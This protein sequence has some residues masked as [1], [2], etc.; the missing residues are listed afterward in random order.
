MP[1]RQ[2][3]D[4]RIVEMRID[5]KRFESGAKNTISTLEKLQKALHLKADSKA[6]DDM[7][8]SV[9]KFDANPMVKSLEK[10]Q[11]S[12]SALE[13]AGMR[14]ITNLTDSI[15]NFATRTAKA[16]TI[17]QVSAGFNKYQKMIESTQTI[18]AATASEV[19]E[20]GRWAN[21][22]EQMQD[23]QKYLDGLLWYADETSYSFVDMTDNLGKFLSAGVDL[24]TAYK[25]MMG[26]AS[27][28]ATAGAKVSD[29]SRALYNISQ[30]MGTGAMKAIDW[31]SIEN[32]NM[33]TIDFK[34]N[35]LATAV[36]LGKLKLVTNDLVDENGKLR[37]GYVAAGVEMNDAGHIINATDEEVEK[38]L[39]TAENMRET[40]KDE[41]FDR[42]VMESVFEKY[43]RFAEMLHQ[44]TSDNY[45]EAIYNQEGQAIEGL[46]GSLLE[47]TD[48]LQLLDEYRDELADPN[49]KVDW[50]AWIDAA[51]LNGT[52]EEQ[53]EQLQALVKLLDDVG[54]AYSETG[55]RMGQEA[56]TFE[57]ALEATKDAVSSQWMKSF[58]Y[59][60]GDYMQAKEFWTQVTGELWDIFAAGGVR[61]NQI[62]KEW[63]RSVDDVTGRTGRDYLLGTWEE[64]IDGETV[65][66]KGALWNLLDAV[67]TI[68]GPIHEAFEEVFGIDDDQFGTT[69]ERL[70]ELTR[71]FQEFTKTL[72]FSE[73]A[74]AGLKTI[75]TGVFKTLKSGIKFAAGVID[76]FGRIAYAIGQIVDAGIRL[77]NGDIDFNGFLGAIRDAIGSILPS[78]EKIIELYTEIKKK[79]DALKLSLSSGTFWETAKQ[80]IPTLTD[81]Q[82]LI[83][84]IT[85]YLGEKFPRIFGKFREWEGSSFLGGILSS[86]ANGF[87]AFANSLKSL[88]FETTT[89][90]EAIARFNEVVTKLFTGLFGDPEELSAQIDNF[91]TTVWNTLKARVSQLSFGDILKLVKTTSI[92]IVLARISQVIN[93]FRKLTDEASGIKEAF[94]GFLGQAGKTLEAIGK[95]YKADAFIKL[96]IAIGILT[97]SLIALSFVPEDKLVNVAVTLAML[98]GVISLFA[99]RLTGATN[100][101]TGIDKSK[102]LSGNRLTIFSSL[103]S[104]LIGFGMVIAAVAGLILVA[105]DL[106][107]NTLFNIFAGIAA[108]ILELTIVIKYLSGMEFSNSKGVIFTLVAIGTVLNM[109]I[110]VLATLAIISRD[111]NTYLSAV[112]GTIGL[113]AALG[114][115]VV[116]IGKFTKDNDN[117]LKVAGSM[118]LM[119]LA[120]QMLIPILVLFTLMDSKAFGK[121]IAGLLSVMI[122]LGGFFALISLLKVDGKKM[123]AL[124][125]AMA[126]I[127]LAIDLMIPALAGF[128]GIVSMLSVA[129]NWKKIIKDLG[130]FWKALGKLAL[131]TVVLAVIGASFIAIGVGVM[132]FGAGLILAGVGAVALAAGLVPL[133]AVLPSFIETLSNINGWKLTAVIA[134]FAVFGLAVLGVVKILKLLTGNNVGKKLTEF[135]SKVFGGLANL[136]TKVGNKIIEALPK[137]LDILGTVLIIIGLYITGIIP[138]LTEIAVTAIITLFNSIA[139]SVEKNRDA[140]VDSIMRII[141]TALGIAGDILGNLFDKNWISENLSHTEQGLLSIL[142]TLLLIKIAAASIMKT[143]KFAATIKGLFTGGGAAAG[144]GGAGGA[145]AGGAGWL[146]S[147]AKSLTAAGAGLG[148]FGGAAT[149]ATAGVG[150][151][152]AALGMVPFVLLD[153]KLATEYASQA[154]TET[155]NSIGGMAAKMNELAETASHYEE[156][157]YDTT[158]YTAQLGYSAQDCRYAQSALESMQT[159]LA[160]SLGIT[161]DELLKQVEAADGDYTKVVELQQ[162]TRDYANE[163]DRTAYIGRTR[164]QM[165]AE[166]F[167]QTAAAAEDSSTRI[168]VSWQE[169]ASQLQANF[170]ELPGFFSIINDSVTESAETAGNSGAVAFANGFIASMDDSQM[171]TAM[172][173]SGFAALLETFLGAQNSTDENASTV[174]ENAAIGI[175][176]SLGSMQGQLFDAGESAGNA[177]YQG[178]RYGLRERSP[179]KRMA[180]VGLYAMLG[181]IKGIEENSDDVNSAGEEVSN[182]FFNAVRQAMTRVSLLAN[183]EFSISPLITPVV[184][185]SNVTAAAS[186]ISGS[187]AGSRVGVAA[188]YSNSISRRLNQVERVASNMENNA[189]MVSGDSIVFNIY[190]SEGM[191]EEAIADTVLSKMQSRYARRGVAFG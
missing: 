183:D 154:Y 68:T 15:Y 165:N 176:N 108:I 9:E 136:I 64:E 169:T 153:N 1:N 161:R 157:L 126:L 49:K 80:Y 87:Q 66:V 160:A 13:I 26:I 151:L 134:G 51:G 142:K 105:R 180:E 12:F 127:A 28:G 7:G 55:F 178:A 44:V 97:A 86:L 115:L 62:L 32:A 166:S 89:I 40:L 11:M 78:E 168:G 30:A 113:M 191:D 29:V 144:A 2:N 82:N 101:I 135:G 162:A 83:A 54:L 50:N 69:A 152:L 159:Q 14:V 85:T 181:M 67:R 145:A 56:K 8:R 111:F 72:G 19:G 106:D 38:M 107:Q 37:E 31:K 53:I 148:E 110:P 182:G 25:S 41:W 164:A 61:R 118:A 185:M 57:D 47:A 177:I 173:N 22:E 155:G 146:A 124:A 147:L 186:N 95:K 133:M 138:Q 150:G 4:E 112:L 79:Y 3:V 122:L 104:S 48:M 33:A 88:G 98:I 60:F 120:I 167:D 163:L 18:M 17:D 158:G 6:L 93:N 123:L 59:I 125:G 143:A 171:Q 43:G 91:I 46:T 190:P 184:D 10:V 42:E 24:D 129:V 84:S 34:R 170:S 96:A 92:A 81:I 189:Q 21:Q 20:N 94:T 45:G 119:A 63:S 76:V 16:L 102:M 65:E 23:V 172:Q 156:C 39:V 100:N 73:E 116:I 27:W 141:T 149:L 90:N 188:D 175:I 121:S 137:I 99:K 130:G 36:E 77:A 35:A 109:L 103:A 58:Q 71:R 187:F 74:Q 140:L 70:R 132:A 52:E 117:L 75:F 114:A 131:L 128:I 5:N 174:A 179:S 139:D